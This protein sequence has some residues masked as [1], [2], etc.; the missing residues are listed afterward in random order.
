MVSGMP[1]TRGEAVVS[2]AEPDIER[3]HVHLVVTRHKMA[4][5]PAVE[6]V[7]RRRSVQ[8]PHVLVCCSNFNPSI[9]VK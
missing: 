6:L 8:C 1:G 7:H 3:G 5:P 4:A 9:T 2:R